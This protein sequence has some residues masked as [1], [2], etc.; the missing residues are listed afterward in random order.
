[1]YNSASDGSDGNQYPWITEGLDTGL[2]YA[3]LTNK[4]LVDRQSKYQHIEVFETTSF[5]KVL[6]LD[7]SFMASEG[8][9]FFYHENLI[10]V[11]ACAQKHPTSALIIGGGDGGSAKELLKHPS[12]SRI[13]LVEIDAEVIDVAREFLGR[14]HEQSIIAKSNGVTVNVII[15]DGLNYVQKCKFKY[16]L[17]ILDLTDSGGPSEMLYTTTFYELCRGLLT[18]AGTLSLH[19]A[20]PFSQAATVS[21]VVRRLQ[22]VF[23]I[24]RPYLVCVPMSGGPWMMACASNQLDASSVGVACIDKTLEERQINNL[25]YYNG[26]THLAAFALPNFVRDLIRISPIL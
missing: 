7:G 2:R 6:R 14:I 13:D 16:D 26:G 12:I 11:A 24:V 19:I 3:I 5:G 9:E 8:D 10:H 15:D 17:I 21:T 22:A 18:Q 4:T 23:S 25:K 20:S 1:M